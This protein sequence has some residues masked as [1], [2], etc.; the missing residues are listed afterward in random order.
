MSGTRGGQRQPLPE[1]TE[2][3]A[4]GREAGREAPWASAAGEASLTAASGE[5]SNPPLPAVADAEGWRGEGDGGGNKI[6]P[7]SSQRGVVLSR[8]CRVIACFS[9]GIIK[10]RR[11]KGF[12]LDVE[13]VQT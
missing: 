8:S 9:H 6:G 13:E 5:G 2:G 1:G 10:S 3:P 7:L 11:D 4:G 12:E